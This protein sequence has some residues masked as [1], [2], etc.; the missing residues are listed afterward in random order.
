M[1]VVSLFTAIENIG[2]QAHMV[3]DDEFGFG[4]K[5]LGDVLALLTGRS[6]RQLNI[7]L[8]IVGKRSLAEDIDL[9]Y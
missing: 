4:H 6:N 1:Y 2:R 9:A 7:I 8:G 5:R 3:R